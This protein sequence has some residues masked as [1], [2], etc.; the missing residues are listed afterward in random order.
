[1]LVQRLFIAAAV[2]V[3]GIAAWTDWRRGQIPNWLTLGALAV[4]PFAHLIAA[5]ATGRSGEA[6][7]AAGF[8]VVGAAACGL[9]P[10]LLYRAG[11]I[12]G[13]DVK[14]LAALGAICG[15][16]L[17][18]E[19]Q[20]Y[21]FLAAALFALGRL[22][23]EGKLLRTLGNSLALLANPLRSREK[24]RDLSPEM[25]TEMRFGPSIFV[26]VLGA[27]FMQLGMR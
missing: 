23:Y 7:E 22:A 11:G 2:V 26:G 25:M 21:S 15:V 16:M 24:R 3:A 1:M 14:L 20:L 17:G 6:I 5:L 10:V 12:Y 13:G 18:V 4:A 9:V 27:A 19:L 8:S